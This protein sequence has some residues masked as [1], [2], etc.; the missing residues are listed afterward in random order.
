MKSNN[1]HYEVLGQRGTT[2]TILAVADDQEE[3]ITKAKEARASYRAV[4]VMRE[5]FDTQ[6]NTYRAGQIFFSGAQTRPSKIDS[7][8]VPSICWK[9]D[10]FYSYEG[11]RAINRLLRAELFEWGITA[12]ELLHSVENVEK[13]QDN[14]TSLQRAVQ[15]TA[16]V[17]VRETGQGVQE[18]IKQ[19]YELIEKGTKLLRREAPSFPTLNGN[20]GMDGLIAEIDDQ[21][22]RSFLLHGALVGYLAAS[23]TYADKMTRL[24]GLLRTDHPA[25]VHE[26]AD[27]F[28]AELL[29]LG[30][31]IHLLVGERPNLKEEMA[32]TA[33]LVIG[34]LN[35]DDKLYTPE[36]RMVNRLIAAGKLVSTQQSLTRYLSENLKG[37]KRLVEGDIAAESKA[38]KQLVETLKKPDGT[39][40]GEIPMMEAAGQ[41][42][43]RWLHPEA[44]SEFLANV[45][46]PDAKAM[47]LLELEGNIVGNANRR[48]LGEFLVPIVI[49]PQGELYLTR[50]GGSVTE[51]LLRLRALQVAVLHSTLQ[52]MHKRKLAERLDDYCC[53]VV[54]NAK[55]IERVTAGEGSIVEK[56]FRLLKMLVENY[57]TLGKAT[58]LVRDAV[59]RCLAAPEFIPSFLAAARSKQEKLQKL[60]ALQTLL[61]QAGIED[62]NP[63]GGS[64]LAGPGS[65]E[66]DGGKQAAAEG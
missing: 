14:G 55:L 30:K 65:E 58:V 5:R 7:D 19:I 6:S 37:K 18:R 42:C 62:M 20:T 53:K 59:R 16:I 60:E 41:R 50:E 45:E 39:W 4:K 40:I 31:V 36:A 51:R 44:I 28:V 63:A 48:K 17:Q 49:S 12:T 11:R 61:K 10:D 29:S 54:R 52:D 1:V 9:V 15:Q 46:H 35:T 26:V 47:R 23:T 2:W 66:D 21:E 38:V 24:L 8:E 34:R 64:S 3:A 32:A 56:C 57:F 33:A 43:A 27:N 22:S 25:W 13:L